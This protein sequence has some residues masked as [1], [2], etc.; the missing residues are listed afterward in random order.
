MNERS[1][2]SDE[3][4]RKEKTKDRG[5]KEKEKRLRTTS[6]TNEGLFVCCTIVISKLQCLDM[7]QLRQLYVVGLYQAIIFCTQFYADDCIII[8]SK[9]FI[10]SCFNQR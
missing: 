9:K 7:P 1:S 5:F 4:E 8:Q 2:K 10:R 3:K 6:P